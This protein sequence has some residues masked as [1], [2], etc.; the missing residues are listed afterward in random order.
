MTDKIKA[1][2]LISG[3]GSNMQNI[4]E[5]ALHGLCGPTEI[6]LVISN[7]SLAEGLQKAEALNVPTEVITRKKY[8]TINECDKI[9][10]NTLHQYEVDLVI[11]AGFMRILGTQ[12]TETRKNTILNIHPSILPSFKGADAL[13]RSYDAKTSVTGCTVHYLTADLDGGAILAVATTRINANDN[14]E[15]IAIRNRQNEHYIYPIV[16]KCIAGNMCGIR[17]AAL[18]AHIITQY[19]FKINSQT[20]MNK[21][22]EHVAI[23]SAIKD[24]YSQYYN[25]K[26]ITANLQE[27]QWI[28]CK[29][30]RYAKGPKFREHRKYYTYY[31]AQP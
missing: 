26:D 13:K 1:A 24:L 11:A 16:I 29:G 20:L 19:N 6:V 18:A 3:N 28:D 4:I 15:Q 27:L 14:Y 12:I 9:I 23:K 10:N 22:H 8:G 30:E 17:P 5:Q 25:I 21:I 2:I 7:N 31:Y